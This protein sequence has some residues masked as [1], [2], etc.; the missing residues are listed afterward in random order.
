MLGLSTRRSADLRL[1]SGEYATGERAKSITVAMGTR[2]AS[3][4]SI[5]TQTTPCDAQS[6][7]EVISD[8]H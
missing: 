8:R 1:T 7:K 5:G 3:G 2:L 6:T 4:R